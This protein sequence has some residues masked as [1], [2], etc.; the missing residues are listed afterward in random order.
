MISMTTTTPK[1]A[2]PPRIRHNS[3]LAAWFILEHKVTGRY[4]RVI[5]QH[6]ALALEHKKLFAYGYNGSIAEFEGKFFLAYRWHD[7]K[8]LHS[9]L[10]LAEIDKT[11]VVHHNRK[12]DLGQGGE[13]PKLFVHNGQLHISWI[14]SKFPEMPMKSFVQ[15]AHFEGELLKGIT[16]PEISGNDGSK[17][18]KNWVFFEA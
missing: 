3:E 2:A 6:P 17:V 15:Y 11:G 7:G 9:S 13:D 12:I 14:E 4:P 10:A 5:D 18:E 16:R 8:T 1:E